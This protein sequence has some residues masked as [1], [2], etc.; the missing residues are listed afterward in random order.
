MIAGEADVIANVNISNLN[1]EEKVRLD[2]FK[3]ILDMVVG[4]VCKLK[5]GKKRM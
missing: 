1:T 4:C 2:L 3:R 5:G